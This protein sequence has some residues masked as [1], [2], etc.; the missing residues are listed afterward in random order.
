MPK[1][2]TLPIRRYPYYSDSE[3]LSK[4]AF[5]KETSAGSGFL[6]CPKWLD[7]KAYNNANVDKLKGHHVLGI[8]S[9]KNRKLL[10]WILRV[11]VARTI[12]TDLAQTK[13][14]YHQI[15]TCPTV[16]SSHCDGK[17]RL[18]AGVPE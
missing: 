13:D 16:H 4:P 12:A 1:V 6:G 8:E 7:C 18:Q 3:R 5:G 2:L 15:C 9:H 14:S 10:T 17:A 11:E